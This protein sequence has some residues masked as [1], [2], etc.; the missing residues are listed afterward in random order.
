MLYITLS[1]RVAIHLCACGCRNQVVTPLGVGQ[2]RVSCEG[3]HISLSPSIGNFQFP[4]RSHYF[5]TKNEVVWL[6]S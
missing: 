4:C 5:I 2:W 3:E 6:G 1:F